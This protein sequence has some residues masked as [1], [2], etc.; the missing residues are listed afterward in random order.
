ML[1]SQFDIMTRSQPPNEAA[2]RRSDAP[3]VQV[4]CMRN[5]ARLLKELK[6]NSKDGKVPIR[7]INTNSGG[8]QAI[9]KLVDKRLC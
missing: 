8:K 7:C 4:A 1:L 6:A 3:V 2:M 5:I 9:H